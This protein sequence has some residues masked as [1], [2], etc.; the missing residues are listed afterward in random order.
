MTPIFFGELFP[1]K[2]DRSFGG[3]G[4]RVERESGVRF[5]VWAEIEFGIGENGT[6]EFE[7]IVKP[8]GLV[9]AFWFGIG[10]SGII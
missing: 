1:E 10:L 6:G 9:R 7:L 2:A 5:G 8:W 3:K 4:R